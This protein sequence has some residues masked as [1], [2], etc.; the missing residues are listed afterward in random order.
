MFV[1]NATSK[2]TKTKLF[3]DTKQQLLTPEDRLLLEAARSNDDKAFKELVKKY[4]SKVARTVI[5]M[6]GYCPEAEDIGQETFF[7]FYRSLHSFRGE[8]GIGTYLTRI[9][10]NL[11]LNEIKRRK[12]REKFFFSRPRLKSD[13]TGALQDEFMNNIADNQPGPG[14]IETKELV[15]QGIQ[16][17]EPPFRAVLVL[18]LL[19]GYSTSETAE[20][21][22][23]PVG[24]VLSRLARAQVKLKEILQPFL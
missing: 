14:E 4:E 2:K 3:T 6:L 22:K 10:I 20:I 16:Q 19:D 9:A 21:L 18:R 12:R 7:R 15:Q 17:L 13:D 5:G 1:D 11:C 23:I 24:T 8:A